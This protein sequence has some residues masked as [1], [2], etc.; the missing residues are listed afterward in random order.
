MTQFVNPSNKIA[1]SLA[2]F[3]LL[4]AICVAGSI[5]L[6]ATTGYFLVSRLLFWTALGLIFLYCIKTEHQPLLLWPEKAQGFKKACI[7]IFLIL[8]L[9]VA[10]SAALRVIAHVFH[11]QAESAVV[12]RLIGYGAPLRLFIV[13]TAAYTEEMLFRGY[14]MPR[15]QLFFKGNWL[16]VILSSLIFGLAHFRYA[17]F[18]NIAGPVFI[19]LVFAAYYQK[20]RN[21]KVL[22][23]CH[24][25]IDLSACS[26]RVNESYSKN[27]YYR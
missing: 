21:I 22:I 10:G 15:L 18:V 7:S 16:P 3:A 27:G 9:I 11:W 8:L 6:S 25:I 26:C 4:I 20:Y 13:V 5:Y 17:T 2:L 24:F 14:L 19:G 1:C 12:S 23:I